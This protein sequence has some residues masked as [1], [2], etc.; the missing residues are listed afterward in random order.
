MP[1]NLDRRVELLVPVESPRCKKRLISLLDTFFKDTVKARRLM[2]EGTYE[3][4]KPKGRRKK[5][6]SQEMLYQQ[7]VEIAKQAVLNRVAVFEPHRA[8]GSEF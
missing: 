3:R 8:A 5:M 6:R 4:V 1:R 7:T 2:P